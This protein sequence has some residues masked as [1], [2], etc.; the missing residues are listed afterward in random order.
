MLGT[1]T[2]TAC[3]PGMGARM[4]ISVV[5]RDARSYYLARHSRLDAEV[6]E[7][8]D[9]RLGR[10]L[11]G[12]LGL[13]VAI[14]ARASQDARVRKAVAGVLGRGRVEEARLRQGR[15]VQV[16][17]L[18]NEDGRRGWSLADDVRIDELAVHGGRVGL[19]GRLVLEWDSHPLDSPPRRMPGCTG[20]AAENRAQRSSGEEETARDEREEPQGRGAGFPEQAAEDELERLP[21]SS[22]ALLAEDGHEAKH[23]DDETG[24]KRAYVHERRPRDQGAPHDEQEERDAKARR[25]DEAVEA[26]NDLRPDDPSV[27][28]QPERDRQ[29]GS[30]E[31]ER[32]PGELVVLLLRAPAP[33]MLALAHACRRL[34]AQVLG[35][36]SWRHARTFGG[37]P[38]PPASYRERKGCAVG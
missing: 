1:S 25:A 11:D 35:T 10:P 27:P 3:L 7:G 32:E 29:K 20:R 9:E 18:V 15:L 36:L 31:D 8:L 38:V 33:G 23:D 6:G 2:P 22:S 26:R 16:R 21:G 12:L 30:D 13:A 34:R 28:S 24:A 19:R 4:R 14:G 37:T 17:E 5:A